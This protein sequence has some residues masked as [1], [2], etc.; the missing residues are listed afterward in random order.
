MRPKQDRFFSRKRKMFPI[1]LFPSFFGPNVSF[2]ILFVDWERRVGGTRG[3]G[4]ELT[5]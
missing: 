5:L 2:F 3:G 1:S 4:N